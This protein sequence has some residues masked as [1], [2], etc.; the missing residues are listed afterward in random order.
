M[1]EKILLGLDGSE[2]SK[3]AA[4]IVGEMITCN[5]VSEIFVVVVYDS[6]PTYLGEPN[7]QVV[8]DARL[9]EA[10][11]VLRAG[12]L[13]LGDVPCKVSTEIVEGSPAEA[14][15]DIA[16]I[17][18]VDLIVLGSRGRGQLTGLL[19]GSTSQKV[20]GHAPCPVLV[21]R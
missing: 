12:L 10:N 6:I 5:N 21:T 1:F 17:R 11:A 19:L 8:I 3:N 14:I 13:A 20:I 7:L 2:H 18:G 16:K 9:D 4:K 15:I